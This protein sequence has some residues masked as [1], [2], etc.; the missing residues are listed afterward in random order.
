MKKRQLAGVL[1]VLVL[2]MCAG[3]QALVKIDAP[4]E[5]TYRNAGKVVIG[6]V[7]SVDLGKRRAE[8]DVVEV[9]K[10]D[11]GGKTLRLQ[12]ARSAD[13]LQSIVAG[14]P[15]VVMTGKASTGVNVADAWFVAENDQQN[16]DPPTWLVTKRLEKRAST[17][18]T[19]QGLVESLRGLS[20][21]SRPTTATTMN[22]GRTASTPSGAR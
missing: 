16:A 18:D 17:P 3:T 20:A 10:G 2:A 4:L 1:G 9:L 12:V 22:S 14:Q 19:T 15:V 5:R 13:V 8:V 7:S 21:G 6:R 11:F